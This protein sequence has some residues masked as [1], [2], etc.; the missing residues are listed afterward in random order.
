M[1]EIAPWEN[2]N[3]PAP[4]ATVER[5]IEGRARRFALWHWDERVVWR[6]LNYSK[7]WWATLGRAATISDWESAI[8]SANFGRAFSERCDFSGNGDRVGFH[9]SVRFTLDYGVLFDFQVIADAFGRGLARE[10]FSG[11][12]G[13]FDHSGSGRLK[14]HLNK[15]RDA[16]VSIL[17]RGKFQFPKVSAALFDAFAPTF[18][19]GLSPGLTELLKAGENARPLRL[20]SDFARWRLDLTPQADWGEWHK[21]MDRIFQDFPVLLPKLRHHFDLPDSSEFYF[22]RELYYPI[23]RIFY[24]AKVS[25]TFW[26]TRCDLPNLTT[27]HE[28]LELGLRLRDGLRPILSPAEIE[29]IL[30]PSARL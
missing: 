15:Y 29:E 18:V 28:R 3:L 12:W 30:A 19:S 20:V 14:R 26:Q 8:A 2:P 5:Q 11:E 22:G 27:A 24:R 7:M 1:P 21:F 23:P 10:K 16:P 4:L 25:G 6:D 17:W 13:R 9:Q